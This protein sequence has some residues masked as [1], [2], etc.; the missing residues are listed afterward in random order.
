MSK[1][2]KKKK[3]KSLP[4]PAEHRS[5]AAAP[6]FASEPHVN[7]IVPA[8]SEMA[9]ESMMPNTHDR[10]G[11]T[12]DVNVP[13]VEN[14]QWTEA[15][16]IEAESTQVESNTDSE[17]H[18]TV[19]ELISL[20]RACA[21]KEYCYGEDKEHANALRNKINA[22]R[23]NGDDCDIALAQIASE[24]MM[25]LRRINS[26]RDP[27]F[28]MYQTLTKLEQLKNAANAVASGGAST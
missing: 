12:S 24:A 20:A 14:V 22:L 26:W 25:E 6:T 21:L 9:K 18:R 17:I 10:A 5:P 2:H 1:K 28:T 8:Q 27:L 3:Q 11:L 23:Q 4:R 15:A 19:L 13:R 16:L 7:G